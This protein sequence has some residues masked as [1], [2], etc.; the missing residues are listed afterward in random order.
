MEGRVT[1]GQ[2]KRWQIQEIGILDNGN[3]MDSLRLRCALRHGDGDSKEK[4]RG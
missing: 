1:I 4:I 2:Q 3:G